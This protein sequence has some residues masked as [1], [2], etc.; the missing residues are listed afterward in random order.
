MLAIASIKVLSY[1]SDLLVVFDSISK[2]SVDFLCSGISRIESV[3][4]VLGEYL[5]GVVLL[6]GSRLVKD[7]L[8]SSNSII[9]SGVVAALNKSL[10][11]R[12][13]VDH[14]NVDLGGGKLGGILR[15]AGGLCS[16]L[17]RKGLSILIVIPGF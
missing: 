6:G 16:N 17:Q 5:V 4:A 8:R 9:K 1:L 13:Q 2:V 11:A 14:S 15:S 12:D 10:P 7:A 3:I